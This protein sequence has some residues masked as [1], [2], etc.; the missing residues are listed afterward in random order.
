[1]TARRSSSSGPRLFRVALRLLPPG[2]RLAHGDQMLAAHAALAREA[3]QRLGRAGAFAYQVREYAALIR[4][5]WNE[6]RTGRPRTPHGRPVMTFDAVRHDVRDALRSLRRAPGFTTLA[7]FILALGIGAS[8]AMF[9]VANG[10]LLRPLAFPDP[11]R[12]VTLW[13]SQVESGRRMRVPPGAYQDYRSQQAVFASM[14]LFGAG[15]L[16]LTGDGEPEQLFGAV[17]DGGYFR[18]LG[19]RPLLGRVILDDDAHEGGPDIVVLSH[20][21]WQRRFG[22]RADI[23]GRQATLDGRPYEIVGVM[24]AGLYPTWPAT[25][26]AITFEESRQQYW[27]P[28][29]L[30]GGFAGNRTAHV[31]GVVARLAPQITLAGAQAAFGT[32]SARLRRA[33]PDAYDG[34]RVV[35]SPLDN[36]VKGAVRPALWALVG[37]VGVLLLIGC[38]NL[39]TLTLARATVRSRELAVRSALGAGR[40]RLVRHLLAESLLIASA[41][42]AIGLLL[43]RLT[44]GA[45]IAFVPADVPRLS[46]VSLDGTVFAFAVA[47]SALTALLFGTLPALRASRP[48]LADALRQE[49][50]GGT[51]SRARERTRRVLAAAEVALASVLVVGAGLLARSFARLT[52]VD[53]GFDP[54]HLL[55]AELSLPGTTDSAAR[56]AFRDG[57][58]ERLGALPGVESAAAAYDDPLS[59]TWTDTFTIEGRDDDEDFGAWQRIVSAAYFRTIGLG[60]H[61]G[62]PFTEVD[63]DHHPRVAIV[64]EAFARRFFAGENPIGRRLVLPAPTR[65]NAPE[66]HEIVGVVGDVKFLGPS[67]PA[68]PAYYVPMAQFPQPD[69]TILVRT[70][71][72]PR[73]LAPGLRGAVH[74]L[75]PAQ[76][77]GTITTERDRANRMVAQPRFTMTLVGLFG[78]L[79]F[80]LAAIGIYGLL[81]YT[82]AQRTRELGVRAALGA[83]RRDLTRLV[84]GQGLRVTLAGVVAGLAGAAA[85]T[86]LLGS[87]LFGISALDPP[88]FAAAALALVGVAI[89]ASYVPVRRAARIDPLVALRND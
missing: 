15:V 14:G 66:P 61:R 54:D 31:Y 5:A 42:G 81:A 49:G 55:V 2:F 40:G 76:A 24:P 88:T 77:I 57:L 80:L 86:R 6:R 60:V 43:A 72:D 1:M 44:L 32:I 56:Q 73:T 83:G 8:V 11:G 79:A 53:P 9:S 59:A 46:A 28:L 68:E 30:E 22:G 58:L 26:G 82:V 64:N 37:A 78:S 85:I 21:L 50:R 48:D 41:G 29:R 47:L 67:A 3:R 62:R 10:V 65:P 25:V 39:A 36:E 7:V 33:Y 84:L 19:V 27:V 51:G 71:G 12:L 4:L 75:S 35:L 17:V 52:A 16:T 34:E 18:T 70:A 13:E 74:D 20:G 23:V 69:M 89:V 45:F 63:D 87:L 38:A